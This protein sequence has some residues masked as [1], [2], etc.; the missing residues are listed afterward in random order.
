M[1][2]TDHRKK[3]QSLWKIQGWEVKLHSTFPWLVC[4]TKAPVAADGQDLKSQ[5]QRINRFFEKTK[6]LLKFLLFFGGFQDMGVSKNNGTPI[7]SHLFI[8]FSI[9][10]TI[11]FLGVSPYF[12][13][14]P[15]G[16]GMYN[17]WPSPLSLDSSFATCWAGLR[18]MERSIMGPV[19]H[20]GEWTRVKQIQA[21]CTI[22]YS[23]TF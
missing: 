7:S 5:Q 6:K 13:K 4:R 21:H 20:P 9:I 14:H 16:T 8:G 19:W 11:H 12:W 10:F 22:N 15:Y 1:S 17:L 23:Y 2:I 3:K 18:E